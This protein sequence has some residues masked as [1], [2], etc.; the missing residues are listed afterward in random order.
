MN[1][2]EA[3]YIVAMDLL[4]VLTICL[5]GGLS[6]L[7]TFHAADLTTDFIIDLARSIGHAIPTLPLSGGEF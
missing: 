6:F 2:K 4:F 7:Q 1:P 5:V 3:L